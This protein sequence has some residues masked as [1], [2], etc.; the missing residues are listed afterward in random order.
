MLPEDMFNHAAGGYGGQGTLC[1]C[2]GSCAA[3]FN[4]VAFDKEKTHTKLTA[5]LIK[6][7]SQTTMPSKRFDSIA[8]FK[9]QYQEAPDS[10]LC[11]VSVSSWILKANTKY[12][13][14]E[15]KDRCGKVTAD[16]VYQAVLMLNDLA[17]KKYTPIAANLTQ[18]T[19]ECMSCHGKGG[20]FNVTVQQN[21]LSCH[22]DH[23]K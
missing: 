19:S 5:D 10:P 14:P 8:K 12:D 7:Y 13:A 9:D 11:H 17:D 21:C 18:E 4:L 15:R 23:T 3:M 6:W 2:L 1:G 16:V 20:D 22:D